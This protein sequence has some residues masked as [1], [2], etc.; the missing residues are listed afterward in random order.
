MILPGLGTVQ[1]KH[2]KERKCKVPKSEKVLTVPAQ[3][4]PVFKVN[5]KFK[6]IFKK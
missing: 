6:E 3:D 5:K 2:R 1:L 4:V